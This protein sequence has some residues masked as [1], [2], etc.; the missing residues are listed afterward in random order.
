MSLGDH[1]TLAAAVVHCEREPTD[2]ARSNHAAPSRNAPMNLSR[3]Q[4]AHFTLAA[5][6][7]PQI[8][9]ARPA[10]PRSRIHRPHGHRTICG[11]DEFDEWHHAVH[12][13]PSFESTRQGKDL[14]RA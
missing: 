11:T 9:P 5:A 4:A 10:F 3:I 7:C 12:T 6:L 8:S 2:K 14:P 1:A 13:I